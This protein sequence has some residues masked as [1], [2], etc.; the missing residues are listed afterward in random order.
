MVDSQALSTG[1]GA[2]RTSNP[3]ALEIM[4]GVVPKVIAEACTRVSIPIIAG[5]L[6][7]T[8]SEIDEV[9]S[10]G[11]K[12]VSLSKEELWDYRPSMNRIRVAKG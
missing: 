11:A 4:P 7:S 6:I 5:G 2:V 10:A 9:L 12:A 3:D 1:V 8:A